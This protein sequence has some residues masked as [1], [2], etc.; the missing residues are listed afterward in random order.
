MKIS[1]KISDDKLSC[2][3]SYDDKP[4]GHV[5]LNVFKGTWKMVPL[6]KVPYGYEQDTK[7]YFN[8]SYEAGKDLVRIYKTVSW[9]PNEDEDHGDF[10]FNLDDVLTFLKT[11]D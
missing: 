8:S 6:F 3:I 7:K 2:E 1:F 9:L 11:G 4:I 10:G 5:K